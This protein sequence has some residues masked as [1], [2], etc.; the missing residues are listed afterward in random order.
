MNRSKIAIY[1]PRMFGMHRCAHNPDSGVP[2]NELFML[3]GVLTVLLNP[4][5]YSVMSSLWIS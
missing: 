5:V 2:G 4:L 1:A 3:G